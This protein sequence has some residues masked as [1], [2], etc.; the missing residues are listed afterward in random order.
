MMSWRTGFAPF[1]PSLQ[2]SH[3]DA[4]S[5]QRDDD[6]DY[7]DDDYALLVVDAFVQ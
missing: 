4:T 3:V 5:L 6:G 2:P 7:D 1:S